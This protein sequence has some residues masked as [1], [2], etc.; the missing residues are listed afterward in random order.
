LTYGITAGDGNDIITGGNNAGGFYSITAGNGNDTVSIGNIAIGYC[1]I[2]VGNGNDTITAGRGDEGTYTITAGD[3]ND[4]ISVGTVSLGNCNIT[5]GNGNDTITGG[6]TIS[7]CST[8]R[9]WPLSCAICVSVSVRAAARSKR[10]QKWVAANRTAE[11]NT[12]VWPNKI[13]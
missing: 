5:A 12:A 11:V 4:T 6:S 7:C 13:S 8:S 9:G 3:G 1:T 2:I 10:F